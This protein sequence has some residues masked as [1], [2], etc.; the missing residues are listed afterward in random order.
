MS[1]SSAAI[2]K[3]RHIAKSDDSM[4]IPKKL[5]NVKYEGKT[6][7]AYPVI[8]H[9]DPAPE[10]VYALLCNRNS[11]EQKLLGPSEVINF[12]A[13]R[14]NLDAHARV[15]TSQWTSRFNASWNDP[16]LLTVL[17]YHDSLGA[18]IND[19]IDPATGV[20]RTIDDGPVD[21]RRPANIRFAQVRLTLDYSDLHHSNTPTSV[22]L[23]YF[24]P[25]PVGVIIFRNG[26]GAE[27]QRF[28]CNIPGDPFALST[29]EFKDQVLTPVGVNGPIGLLPPHLGST[30]CVMNE[31]EKLRAIQNKILAVGKDSIFRNLQEQLA[32]G[33]A[34]TAYATCERI[35]MAFTDDTGNSQ[36]LSVLEFYNALM[37]AAVTFLEDGTYQFNLAN[38]FVNNLTKQLK[39]LFMES[40][41]DHLTFSDLSRDGQ[42]KQ[43]A[44][45]LLIA[46][47]CEKKLASTKSIVQSTLSDTQ[48][49][50]M[51]Q[52]LSAFNLNVPAGTDV[53]NTASYLSAAEQTLQKY[54]DSKGTS[55]SPNTPECW[56]CTGKHPWRNK[57]T[58][59]IM[60]P[61]KDK[62]GVAERAAKMHKEYVAK[63]KEKRGGWVQRKR[64]KFS[65]LSDEQ[66]E[67]G[68]QLFAAEAAKTGDNDSKLSF[69]IVPAYHAANSTNKPVLEIP[70]DGK[71]PHIELA[72][73]K[74]DSSLEICP[75]VKCLY[76]TGA[77]MTTGFMDFWLPLLA[78]HPEVV[79]DVETS[80]D[81][82]KQH[83]ILGGVVTGK[84]GDMA[85][86]TTNLTVVVSVRLRYI[87]INGQSLVHK[88][89]LGKHV[90][91]NT[92]LGKPFIDTLHC[93]HDSFNKVVEAKLLDSKPF[94]VAEMVPQ[95]YACT[96]AGAPSDNKNYA[97]IVATLTK[98][99]S[100]SAK[101]MDIKPTTIAASKKAMLPE[102]STALAATTTLAA[103]DPG[104]Y[105]RKPKPFARSLHVDELAKLHRFASND[106]VP[107]STLADS[108][109]SDVDSADEK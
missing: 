2:D 41:T 60:C 72:L 23:D 84:D 37:Q 55:K 44:K 108:D 49:F 95:R 45:N 85:H 38:H 61:N 36:S 80:E 78:A 92:I 88:I 93:V 5:E 102:R 53:S 96:K 75:K 30:E 16:S 7:Q 4:F 47:K 94:K 51:K 26:A 57:S 103:V 21:S 29:D 100:I 66:K 42:L 48:A 32:P 67:I 22:H 40:C 39:E 6:I 31:V 33:F 17:S 86:H 109:D 56:G 19:A 18:R 74:P 20:L 15:L 91:V 81:G 71:L 107:E 76:D 69:V 1:S 73:G 105:K 87:T 65:Q 34:T 106:D 68:R 13:S 28:T 14:C 8:G 97:A 82:S 98:L 43:L 89:A 9:D 58:K 77:C 35:T 25:L 62:P 90:G 64:M 59:E 101:S 54:S 70:I 3:I 27:T 12:A 52:I 79:E 24:I 10:R 46:T 11:A 104:G 99:Q 83:I 50:V 63:L